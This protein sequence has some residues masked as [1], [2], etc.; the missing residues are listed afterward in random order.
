[1]SLSETTFHHG[2]TVPLILSMSTSCAFS[3]SKRISYE[4]KWQLN[5][6]VHIYYFQANETQKKFAKELW[7]RI[8]RECRPDSA[9]QQQVSADQSQFPN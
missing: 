1:M 8:R 3:S 2:G 4:A 5:S 9:F 7:E 6:D